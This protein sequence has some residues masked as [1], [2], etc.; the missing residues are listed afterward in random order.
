MKAFTF[1]LTRPPFR[2]FFAA[3]V[4]FS[5]SPALP[6]APAYS[7][8]WGE[9]GEKWSAAGRLPDFSRA[10]YHQ[11]E[12]PIPELPRATNVRDFGAV[13]DGT[14]D[15][16]RAIQAALDATPAGAVYLP[17][18]RYLVSDFIR[19]TRSGVVLRGAGPEQSILWFPRGLDA[20]HPRARKTATGGPASGYSFDGAFVTLEGNTQS[21]KLAAVTALA[22]RG[23]C[24]IEV[25][26]SAGLTVGQLVLLVVGETPDQSLKTYLYNGDPGDIAK[27]KQRGT[28]QLF[29]IIALAGNRVT[30]DRPLRFETRTEWRPE[31][32]AFNPTVTESGIEHLGFAFP[33]TKYRGHFKEDGHNAIELRSVFNCW[34]RDVAIH[35]G[36]LGVNVVASGNTLDGILLTADIARGT[37]DAGVPDCT[38]HHAIQLKNSEDNLVTNFD[39]RAPYVHDLSVERASGN[40]FAQGRGTD[41]NFDHHKDTPYENLFTDIDCG[42]G[43]RVWRNGGGPSLGRP[44]A[45]WSTFWNIRAAGFIAPPPQ[46]WG[47]ATMNFV[48]VRTKHPSKTDGTAPWWEAIS[49]ASLEPANLHAAQ[50]A[51]RLSPKK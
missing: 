18:G 31:L 10:G 47:P 48:A 25:D 33:G 39:V 46:G 20:I 28:Q 13:G 51:R 16:T 17:P 14:T 44:S 42:R 15:D 12:R 49:P 8:L 24:E 9:A 30:V 43:T 23:D 50:F 32:R 41:L 29:R 36:D 22:Q 5:A 1:P 40:V 34:V 2:L 6:A 26:R 38:G 27:G 3:A 7:Q 19:I 11:G 4:F 37:V 21:K 35:N 45:G